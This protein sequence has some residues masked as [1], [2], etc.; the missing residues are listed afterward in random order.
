MI[1]FDSCSECDEIVSE[2]PL[3]HK[4]DHATATAERADR[5]ACW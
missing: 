1:S 5:A 4:A 3:Y 2:K